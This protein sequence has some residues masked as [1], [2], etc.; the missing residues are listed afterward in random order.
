MFGNLTKSL[1]NKESFEDYDKTKKMSTAVSLR[2]QGN[3]MLLAG[4]YDAIE[5]KIISWFKLLYIEPKG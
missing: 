3:S 4:F 2:Y 5:N 1:L